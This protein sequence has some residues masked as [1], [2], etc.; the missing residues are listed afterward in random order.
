MLGR[1]PWLRKAAALLALCGGAVGASAPPVASAAVSWTP[2][3]E[4]QFLLDVNIRQLKLGDGVRAYNTPEGTCVVL[5]DFLTALDVPMRIDLTAKKASGWAFKESNRIAIDYAAMTVGYGGKSEPIAP[6]TI[7]ETPDGWCIQTAALSR[8]F[9]IGVKPVTA[10]S[11]LVL[12]SEAKLPVELAV[13]RQRRAA[14]IHPASFDL[15]SLP[16]VR[17]PY[18]M[19]RT[20]AL[21]F[22]VSAGVTYRAADGVRVDRQSSIYAAGELAHLSYDAQ[23]T[24]N[25]KGIPRT[26]RLRAFRSDPDGGLL[27]PLKATHFGFGDVEGF[28]SGLT[29]SVAS[30]RGAVITNRPLA[31]RA[32]F[33]RTHFEGD[34]P[35]GWEA[36]IYRNGEL[37]GF[38]KPTAGQRYVFDDVQLLYGENRIQ[39]ILY[40]PQGQVRTR[41]E[42]IDVGK[43]NVPAGKTW[44][45]AGVSQ[46]GRDLFTL[47]KPPDTQVLPK[48]QAAVSVEH[49]IDDRTSVGAL[50]RMMLIDDQR[51][52]F[53]EGNVRRSVGAAL[54]EVGAARESNGGMAAHA[55]LLGKVGPVNVSAEALL[56]NDFHLQGSGQKQSVRE[57]RATFDLPVKFGHAVLPA[58]A[59]LHYM[60]H[61][62]GS[63]ELDAAARLAANFN[64]F[65]LATDLTYKK[66][67]L[68][69]GPAPPDELNLG[70]IGT[71]RFRDVR[72]RA[73]VD[74]D[75]APHAQ[76]RTAEIS[77][78]WSAS[79]NV[80]WEG[81]VTYDRLAHQGR[82][83]ISHISRLDS[84]AIALTG[85]A[86]TDGSV[87]FGV[88]LNFSLDPQRGLSLSRRPLAQAGAVHATVYRDL[89]GDGVRDDAEPLEKGALVT[90][91]STL[92]DRVTDAK[93]AVTVGGLSPYVPIAVGLDET[94][95]ADPMLVPEKALQ[96]VVPRPGVPA[97]VQIGRVSGGDIEGAVV[98][99]G[100]LG[101][102]GLELELVDSTGKVVATATSDFDGFFLFE[103]VAYGAYTVRVGQPS[104][105][106]AKIIAELSV[107][108]ELNAAKSIARLGAITVHPL[109][110]LASTSAPIATP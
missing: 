103:R 4:D 45:W 66:Q 105:I 56:A 10:G 104:A 61:R 17:I 7:R 79:E 47:E 31:V 36:E 89:N 22:V 108:L 93:G 51:L 78:Y 91:G 88:N 77:A 26:V 68:R 57:L 38:A 107:H 11:V 53:L 28:D 39:I 86:A 100:G 94:S 15:K 6:G 24:T 106:A 19:W 13:E 29:G 97:D 63:S 25:A 44:Y 98:K 69:S 32:A 95:L 60:D 1:G 40:G 50:A 9:G 75:V 42:L 14:Q 46:P 18:R 23:I 49:G 21:D 101:F 99:S 27:G 64:R 90:T 37:L 59:D 72:L 5:G 70:L 35:A 20:P 41:D 65:N 16:Q 81:D 76:F 102:E 30:G 84:M 85:E 67:Y 48:A 96:V 110:V 80:D 43:D 8:W 34:L 3:P 55:Q 87:A 109:P 92:A 71:G 54:I 52:T 33:D 74:F 12:Q 73:G 83:R 2:D 82:A 58:H 62:D